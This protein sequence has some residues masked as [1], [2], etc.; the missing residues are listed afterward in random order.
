MSLIEAASAAYAD[1]LAAT[2]GELHELHQKS[3]NEFLAAARATAKVRL[4]PEADDLDWTYTSPDDL[5]E[6]TEEATA[7]LAK[8]RW[9]WLRYRYDH[10]T[11]SVDF[12]LVQMCE[13][14]GHEKAY[15]V[16]GLAM[17]GELLAKGGER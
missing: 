15:E 10:T 8:G 17:L 12:E 16:D 6:D 7:V 1:R 14:C 5:D 2:E 9:D 13:H 4:G 11:E 3:V